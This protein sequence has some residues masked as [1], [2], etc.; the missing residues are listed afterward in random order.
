MQSTIYFLQQELREAK[1]T[2][3]RLQGVPSAQVKG[4]KSPAGS[5]AEDVDSPSSPKVSICYLLQG[6]A[7]VIGSG[8]IKCSWRP[9]SL[10]VRF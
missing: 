8:L 9:N 7:I 6:Q 4:H 1:E 5:H 3:A 10:C 2:I